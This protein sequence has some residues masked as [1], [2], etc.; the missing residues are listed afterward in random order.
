[1]NHQRNGVKTVGL[2]YN[3]EKWSLGTS[4]HGVGKRFSLPTITGV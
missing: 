3:D 1:M 2:V 4:Q